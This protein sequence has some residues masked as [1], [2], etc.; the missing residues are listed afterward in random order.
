MRSS[1]H[2]SPDLPP[3]QLRRLLDRLSDRFSEVRSALASAPLHEL[4]YFSSPCRDCARLGLALAR[5]QR[6][7]TAAGPV[8]GPQDTAEMPLRPA[9]GAVSGE[10]VHHAKRHLEKV[11]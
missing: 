7:L 10:E 4:G 1:S 5:A 11:V 2:P 3:A 8:P 6:G 9:Q